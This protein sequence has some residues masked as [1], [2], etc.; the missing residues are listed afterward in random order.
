MFLICKRGDLLLVD[1]DGKQAP[2]ENWIRAT[3]QRTNNS[4]AVSKANVQ[5]LPTLTKPPEEILVGYTH[6]YPLAL[7]IRL[8]QY[9]KCIRMVSPISLPVSVLSS[10]SH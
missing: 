8:F 5:F 9:N 4:G 10:V 1:K 2:D 3:N 7:R 6:S